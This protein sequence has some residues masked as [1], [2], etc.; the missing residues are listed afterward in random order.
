M[1]ADV[2]L[3]AHGTTLGQYC[4]VANRPPTDILSSAC[5]H[6]ALPLSLFTEILVISRILLSNVAV[7]AFALTSLHPF[8]QSSEA[9]PEPTLAPRHSSRSH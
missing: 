1:L 2:E 3:H 9:V 5:H 4:Q 8:A 7:G 6:P